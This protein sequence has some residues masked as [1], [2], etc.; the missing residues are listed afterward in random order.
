MESFLLHGSFVSCN[1]LDVVYLV[2]RVNYLIR[3]IHHPVRKL[4]RLF[5]QRFL[6]RSLLLTGG[7]TVFI[8]EA[9]EKLSILK[10]SNANP[11]CFRD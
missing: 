5:N 3:K 4:N 1:I 10:F 7:Y 2:L 11:I 9:L 8:T 6:H